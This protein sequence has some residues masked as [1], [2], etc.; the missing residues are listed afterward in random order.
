MGEGVHDREGQRGGNRLLGAQRR[1]HLHDA[2][3]FAAHQAHRGH[4]VE[5]KPGDRHPDQL[6][7]GHALAAPAHDDAVAQRM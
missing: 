5:G 1:L 3:E 4:M 2:V 6:S 7:K